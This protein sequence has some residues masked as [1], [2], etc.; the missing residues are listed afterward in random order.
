LKNQTTLLKKSSSVAEKIKQRCLKNQAALFD[1]LNKGRGD[2]RL[3]NESPLIMH[4]ENSGSYVNWQEPSCQ[5][6]SI[7]LSVNPNC[8]NK[9][10]RMCRGKILPLLLK[11]TNST[12]YTYR[13]FILN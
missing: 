8:L 13:Q 4:A 2:G 7:T 5:N 6:M 11:Y 3:L 12:G 1:F 9:K 10:Y